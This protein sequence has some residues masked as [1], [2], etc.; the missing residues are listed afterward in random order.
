MLWC[1]T[2]LEGEFK[3]D[4]RVTN[5]ECRD[6]SASVEPGH[7]VHALDMRGAVREEDRYLSAVQRG[8]TIFIFMSSK[9]V[10]ILEYAFDW[11]LRVLWW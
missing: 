11:R 9:S 7:L 10:R 5:G 2:H 3:V 8:H 1:G 4:V 6:A